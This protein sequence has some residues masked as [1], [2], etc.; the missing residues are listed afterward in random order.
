MRAPT[1]PDRARARRVRELAVALGRVPLDSPPALD[2][3][4]GEIRD[5]LEADVAMAYGIVDAGD[6]LDLD[7]VHGS[8]TAK[9]ARVR[10]EFADW[11]RRFPDRTGWAAY[12]P[13]HPEPDQRNEVLC[14]R[15]FRTPIARYL[16]PKIGVD[17]NDCIR[18]LV[19]DGAT[20]LAWVG[21]YSSQAFAEWQSSGLKRLVTPLRKRLIVERALARHSATAAALEFMLESTPNVAF[22]VSDRGTIEAGNGLAR[23]ALRANRSATVDALRATLRG[24][25][26]AG[27]IAT[28]LQGRGEQCWYLALGRES[29]RPF[30]LTRA[31][32]AQSRFHLTPRQTEILELVLQG[33]SGVVIARSLEISPK[34]LEK[35]MAGLY[36]RVD[37]ANRAE[38]VA[39]VAALQI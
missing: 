14:T 20:L 30:H 11:L 16:Y 10:E 17:G 22:I 33:M 4:I 5:V 7:F 32:A 2:A 35:H 15:H 13:I 18:V 1:K 19:C 28:P 12:N 21:I 29:F 27:Y 36:D 24:A 39:R 25:N 9:L 3:H 38:L 6:H 23:A 8:G 31:A 34:T 37:V 26:D